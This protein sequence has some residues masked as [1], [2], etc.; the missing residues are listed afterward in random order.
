MSDVSR[1]EYQRVVEENK[2]LT[3]DIK[4]LVG[5][6]STEKL[7]CVDKWKTIFKEK[8]YFTELLT[9][10]RDVHE[11]EVQ[12]RYKCLL[13]GRDKFTAKQPHNCVGGFRK[14]KILW[15]EIIVR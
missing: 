15:E 2:R 1:S 3:K 5:P 9:I 7:E 8:S 14:R 10:I 11:Q 4:I 12:K 13:C 6:D